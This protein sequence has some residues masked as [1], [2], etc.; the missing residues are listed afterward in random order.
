MRSLGGTSIVYGMQMNPQRRAA[1]NKAECNPK[2][3]VQNKARYNPKRAA[4]K[5]MTYN[6]KSTESEQMIEKLGG[7]RSRFSRYGKALLSKC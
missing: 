1:H 4:Q 6:P 2:R 3:T 5:K 7:A